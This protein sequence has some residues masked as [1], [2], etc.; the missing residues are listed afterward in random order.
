MRV[1]V[2]IPVYNE[3]PTIEECL[4]RV[5]AVGLDK[6]ILVVDDAS[7]DGTREF[8]AALRRAELAHPLPADNRGKE[9]P[10]DEDS[11]KRLAT[12]S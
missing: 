7:T 5:R 4:K 3:R 2:V 1:S 8:L 9:R 12:S 11:K 6:E 10:C